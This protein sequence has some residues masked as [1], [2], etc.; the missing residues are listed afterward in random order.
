MDCFPSVKIPVYIL[1]ILFGMGSWVA[2]NG[3]WVELP[4]LVDQSPE[5]WSL[6]SY[7]TIIAQIANVGPLLYILVNKVAPN[8][9]NE[10]HGVFIIVVLGTTACL[11]LV[12]F[13]K[14]TSYVGGVKHSTG[15][16]VSTFLLSLVDCTSSVVFLPYMSIFKPQ[17]IS[18]L[19]IGEG[20]SGLVP[21]LVAIGQG[22]G[23]TICVNKTV[24][25]TTNETEIVAEYNP[26]HFPVEDFF[27]FLF[28]IMIICGLAF[29]LL[30]YLPYCK[31]EHVSLNADVSSEVRFRNADSPS[32]SYSEFRNE[33]SE[34]QCSISVTDNSVVISRRKFITL[35]VQVAF[36][37]A[38]TNGVLPSVSSYAT[39]P[40]GDQA[41]HL[42]ATLSSIANPL[43][44]LVAFFL[45]V[46]SMW[47]IGSTVLTGFGIGIYVLIIAAE[48]PTPPMAGEDIGAVIIVTASILVTALMTFS[49]VSIATVLRLRGRMALLWCGIVTQVGSAIGAILMFLIV[50]QLKLFH[51]KAACT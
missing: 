3:M 31:E 16:L 44:C 15:L 40:Y 5:G 4:I 46:L 51:Q 47:V 35:L 34:L 1:V 29:S 23:K 32:Y 2:I 21:S 25:F 43:T 27:Y 7:I 10:K 37:N 9:F 30:H 20:L 49:K 17:Y 39:I 36:I 13:W 18:A 28:S 19:Y 41:Y 48:S 50:N 6:P 12:F 45:P 26:P 22:V 24:N 42:S 11:L 8:E 33:E 14:D 38:L